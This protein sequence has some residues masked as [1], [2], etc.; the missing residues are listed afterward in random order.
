MAHHRLFV[1][2]RPPAAIRA[3][4]RGL[5]DGVP[6]ARWQDDEQLHLT[7]RFIGAV[8][9]HRAEDIAAAL[10]RVRHAPFE[11]RLDQWGTFDREGRVDTL[12][13]GVAPKEDARALHLKIDRAIGVVGIP[14]DDRAYLPHVTVARIPRGA[15]VSPDIVRDLPAPPALAFRVEDFRLYESHLGTAGANYEA[16]AR[17]PLG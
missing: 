17:H 8:D 6:G 4:L 13:I 14:Q 16:I 2:I 7:L 10:G 11:V 3:A 9:H 1:A 15:G 5:C 12:W